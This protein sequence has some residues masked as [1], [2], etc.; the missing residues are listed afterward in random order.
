METIPRYLTA[1][2]KSA[3]KEKA[4]ILEENLSSCTLCPR[5]CGVNR[6][7]GDVG[8]CKAPAELVISSVFA[9]YGEE[10]PLVGVGGSGTIFLAHC[11]LKCIFC[12]NYEISM[13]GEGVRYSEQELAAAMILLQQKGCHNINFVTPTHYIPAILRGLSLAVEKGLSIPLVYNCSGY[14]SLEVVKLLE[15]VVDI[16]MPDIKFLEQELSTRYCNAPD[17]P[18]VIREV[19]KEMHRQVGDLV[20]D[21][22]GIVQRGLLIRHLVMPSHAENTRIVLDFIRQEL[23]RDAFVNIMA[24]YHP[25]FQASRFEEISRRPTAKEH[26]DAVEYGRKIGLRRAGLH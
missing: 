21:A 1:K 6:L 9:H 8:Y 22:R 10:S 11:N 3:L 4:A 2:S 26:S 24:Q 16:Y 13:R 7:K 20:L 5:R 25:C 12:Q 23:S 19:V 15:G 14:E 17:Y 18:D